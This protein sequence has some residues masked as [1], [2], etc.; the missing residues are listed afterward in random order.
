MINRTNIRRQGRLLGSTYV[1][2]CVNLYYLKVPIPLFGTTYVAKGV[3]EVVMEGSVVRQLT[4]IILDNIEQ[5]EQDLFIVIQLYV[6]PFHVQ[7]Q[8]HKKYKLITLYIVKHKS[9]L[10]YNIKLKNKL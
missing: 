6:W 2:E 9:I 3:P 1:A 4:Q 7:Y 5:K 8:L 10:L